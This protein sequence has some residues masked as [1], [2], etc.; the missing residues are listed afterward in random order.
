MRQNG[1]SWTTETLVPVTGC[2]KISEGCMDCYAVRMSRRL[3]A[4]GLPDYDGVV[5]QTEGGKWNFTGTINLVPAA[6]DAPRKRK[7]P[8]LYFVSSMSDIFHKDVPFEY[9][10]KIFAMMRDCGRHTF[11]VLTKRA[12]RMHEY[13]TTH[14]KGEVLPNVWLGVTVEN[15]NA[16]NERVP[17]LLATPAALRFLSCE[18]LLGEVN[19]RAIKVVKV[20]SS[21]FEYIPNMKETHCIDALAGDIARNVPSWWFDSKLTFEQSEE[22]YNYPREAY[23]KI[24]WV[25]VGGESG[26]LNARAMHP[27]WARKLCNDC[28]RNGVMFHFKQHGNKVHESQLSE[29]QAQEH[30][31]KRMGNYFRFPAK[32]AI[33][34]LDGREYL[35]I[36]HH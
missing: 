10:D 3:A 5:K 28:E 26:G 22:A 9:I 30:A 7:K 11:Q 27:D 2:T 20:N 16:A 34:T 36:P 1:I 24:D 15:Q 18:P 14:Y 21:S 8:T 35:D 12:D 33:K 19:L 29:E 4:M 17:Y 23:P 32:D 31:A 6:L 13:M 25:I